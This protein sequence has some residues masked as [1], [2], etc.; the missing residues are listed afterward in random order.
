MA[1]S[2]HVTRRDLDLMAHRIIAVQDYAYAAQGA[3]PAYGENAAA[4]RRTSADIAVVLARA[5]SHYAAR[6]RDLA[7]IYGSATGSYLDEA[8]SDGATLL[9]KAR[10]A[11]ESARAGAPTA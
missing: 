4:L 3:W 11:R 2:K 8:L 6:D 9:R 1:R 5:V 10:E 7:D